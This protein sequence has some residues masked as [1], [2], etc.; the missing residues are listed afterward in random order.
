MVNYVE[1]YPYPF[2]IDRLCWEFP[3]LMP[4]DW[5]AQHRNGKCSPQTVRDYKA[6]IDAIVHK[7]GVFSLCFHPHGWINAEQIVELIDYAVRE[8]GPK[9]KFLS[10]RDVQQRLDANLLG[11]Q[12]LRA[13]DGGD[14]GVRICDVDHD[15]FMDVVIANDSARETRL[16]SP[17][18]QSWTTSD[19][20]VALV[21]KWR[22]ASCGPLRTL[23][24]A[25]T[26]RCS[27]RAGTR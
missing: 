12:S 15:G 24:R 11:G 10:F 8:H 4:S 14:N 17:G 25:A 7:Q 9:V 1:D 20:P 2:V 21:G 18:A 3:A 19:F 27:E 22:L 23:R 5:D 16:W 13:S 6:A 26:G